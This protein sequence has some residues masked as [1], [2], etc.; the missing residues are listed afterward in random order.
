[1]I[2]LGSPKLKGGGILIPGLQQVKSQVYLSA[3]IIRGFYRVILGM[4]LIILQV[5][6]LKEREKHEA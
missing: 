6:C 1:M 3:G 5:N 4:W 2:Y